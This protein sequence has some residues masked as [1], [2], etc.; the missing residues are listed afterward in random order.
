MKLRVHGATDPGLVRRRNEDNFLV[1]D[2]HGVFAVADGIGGMPGGDVASLTAVQTVKALLTHDAEGAT[3]DLASLVHQVH[4]AVQRAGLPFGAA[5]IGT[6]LT[7]A[8][9][10]EG[11]ARIAHVGDSFALLLRGGRCRAITREHNVEN[12]R[13]ETFAAAS[14]PPAYRYALTRA[15]GQP[16]DVA[17]DILEEDLRDG[18]RLIL[19]T[20]G[21][22]DVVEEAEIMRVC[23]EFATP[24]HAAAQ[25]ISSALKR[26]G[27]DN[28]T[29]VVISAVAS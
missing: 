15:I 12:D 1:D 27:P 13:R 18:D 14:H 20:D 16:G 6:T 4:Q 25:L 21:L 22:T 19:A 29:V 28:I 26:G 17:V 5:G 7:L 3:G 24:E 2:D 23:T 9:V 10:Q 8:H 11:R